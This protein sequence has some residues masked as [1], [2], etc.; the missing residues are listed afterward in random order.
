MMAPATLTYALWMALSRTPKLKLVTPLGGTDFVMGRSPSTDRGN[1]PC[2]DPSAL[3]K[4]L[5]GR[6]AEPKLAV[7]TFVTVGEINSQWS[8]RYYRAIRAAGRPRTW[9][10]A[11]LC[12]DMAP[13]TA[14][15]RLARILLRLLSVV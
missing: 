11:S 2:A 6:R 10:S 4:R 14:F 13:N 5:R 3:Y 1:A 15:P 8:L 12:R 7:M 9:Q